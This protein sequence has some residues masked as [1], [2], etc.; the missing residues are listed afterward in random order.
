MTHN[1]RVEDYRWL[2]KQCREAA[3]TASTQEDRGEL[4]DRAKT[5]DFL[6]DHPPRPES[7]RRELKE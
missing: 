1:K 5:W 4:L 2:A 6:A 7:H 3:R